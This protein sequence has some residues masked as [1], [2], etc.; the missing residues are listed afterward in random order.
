MLGNWRW[1]EE[2]DLVCCCVPLDHFGGVWVGFEAVLVGGMRVLDVAL[3][4]MSGL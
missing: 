2:Y 3:N 1:E 4:E